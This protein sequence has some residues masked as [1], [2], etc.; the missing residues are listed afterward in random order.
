M[1]TNWQRMLGRDSSLIANRILLLGK[2]LETNNEIMIRR[3]KSKSY[4][5]RQKLI[6]E[7]S[8]LDDEA[9]NSQESCIHQLVRL[10]G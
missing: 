9:R 2:N 7:N 1:D 10:D 6:A 5:I 4:E 8:R 3:V